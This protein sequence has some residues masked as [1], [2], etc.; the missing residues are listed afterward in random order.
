MRLIAGILLLAPVLGGCFAKVQDLPRAP[1]SAFA[2]IPEADPD[3]LVG[4]AISGGG[5]RAAVFAAA[6]LEALARV[7]VPDGAG[8]ERSLLERVQYVSSVSGGSLAAGYFA[9]RKPPRR[10]PVLGPGPAGLSP[11]YEE[12]FRE[13]KAA[14]QENFQWAAAWRQIAFL[15]AFNPTKAAFSLAEAWDARFFHGMTFEQL[16]ARERA[17]DSPRIILNGT[18]YNSGR[19]FAMTTLPA[20]DFD[21]D[22]VKR[23]LDDLVARSP[24]V[25]P[26]GLAII[27]RNLQEAQ[28]QFLPL[29]FDQI[30]ADH[31]RLPLSLAVASSASF[32]PAVGPITYAVGGEPPY[33]HVGDGGLFDN[34]GTES[35]TTLFLKKLGTEGTRRGLIIVVDAAFPFSAN[36]AFLD[37]S[38][39]GFQVFRKDPARVVGIMEER[40]NA[41]QL[42]LWDALRSEGVLLPGFER[43]RVEVLQH[44]EPDWGTYQELPESCRGDF[45]ADVTARAIKESVSQVPTRFRVSPCN[46]ALM[47]LAAHK[48]VRLHERRLVDFLR[49]RR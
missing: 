44:T 21:Y 16:Y 37:T 8:G 34:L 18:S 33:Q 39:R 10:E 19:R 45:P 26:E 46:A 15:R 47:I 14:M 30:G 28:T 7:R 48:V 9:A 13:L 6:V 41:Y 42:M 38:R 29:T 20:S 43:L 11:A 27:R 24:R 1:A 35:L 2:P 12:F 17:G 3:L 5:S 25:N 22:F 4:V 32:P 31:R 23:L 36:A 49:P 40:A